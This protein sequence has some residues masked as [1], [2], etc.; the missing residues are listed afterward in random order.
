MSSKWLT[1][2]VRKH[3]Y[4]R[5]EYIGVIHEFIPVAH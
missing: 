2:M 4:A 3:T 1:E 5:V